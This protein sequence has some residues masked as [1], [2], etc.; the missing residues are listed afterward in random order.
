M[1]PAATSSASA[2]ASQAR[3]KTGRCGRP[4]R[5]SRSSSATRTS[6]SASIRSADGDAFVEIDGKVFGQP[7]PVGDPGAKGAEPDDKVVIEMVRFPS[8]AHGAKAV[9]VEVLGKRGEPGV[10]TLSIIREFGLPDEFPD[11]VLEDAREQAEKFDES[12]GNRLDL[13]GETI[14][15]IDPGRCP[16]FRRRD[17]ARASSTTATGCSACTSP[18][19][20]TSCRPK[21]PLD[22]EAR[23]RATSVYLPDR[24]IPM[25]P[26]IISNNLASLQPDKVR[27][28]QTVLDRVHAE[29]GRR[30]P[31]R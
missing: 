10:D 24:V 14:I 4:A 7:I 28:T 13:T 12:I 1:P 30:L 19:C 21:T 31:A 18:T 15:T 2:S 9:I 3:N 8:H 25:L 5:S 22:R 6:S 17:L 23:E 11:D 16:R 27:Y 26:E 20:R 29:G